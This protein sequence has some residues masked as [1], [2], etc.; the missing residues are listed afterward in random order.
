MQDDEF[1]IRCAHEAARLAQHSFSW[2]RE[3]GKYVAAYERL[4]SPARAPI[5]PVR[6]GRKY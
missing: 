3:A 2:P 6:I 4:L 5:T 1:R